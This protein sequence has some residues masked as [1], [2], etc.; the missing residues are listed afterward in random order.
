MLDLS[1]WSMSDCT[2]NGCFDWLTRHID[3]FPDVYVIVALGESGSDCM[4]IYK[5]RHDDDRPLPEPAIAL[6][7]KQEYVLGC[8][9]IVRLGKSTFPS[10][11]HCRKSL[12]P[13]F[14]DVGLYRCLLCPPT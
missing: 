1:S 14:N 10:Q 13:S 4:H 11:R 9:G 5:D 3:V 12:A 8:H 7:G 6:K 2:E